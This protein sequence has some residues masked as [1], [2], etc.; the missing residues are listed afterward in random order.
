MVASRNDGFLLRLTGKLNVEQCNATYL[1]PQVFV[2]GLFKDHFTPIMDQQIS[3]ASKSREG[4]F[5]SR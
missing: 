1:D 2:C 5:S 4:T 3:A